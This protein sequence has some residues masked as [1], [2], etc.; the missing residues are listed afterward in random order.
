MG[1]NLVIKPLVRELLCQRCEQEYPVWFA[2]DELWN[3]VCRNYSGNEIHFLCLT[4]FAVLA[5]KCGI[6]PAAWV[7]DIKKT[8]SVRDPEDLEA[9]FKFAE[10]HWE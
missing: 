7:V 6:V 4:C 2:P 3:N 5:E 8:E 1:L 9:Q 10:L